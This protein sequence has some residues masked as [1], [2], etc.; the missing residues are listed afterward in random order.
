MKV[1]YITYLFLF[2]T[3]C[4]VWSQ[5]E[6]TSLEIVD[7]KHGYPLMGAHICL[8]SESGKKNYY[9]A[10]EDGTSA[11]YL[12]ENSECII[13]Y[14]GYKT[15]K[16]FLI[17]GTS[18]KLEMIP[19]LLMI[20]QV[21]VTASLQP[22]K[23]DQS[24]YKVGVVTAET[25]EKNGAQNIRDALRFQPN[26]NLLED[27]VLGSRI[28]MQGLE[29][30][31]VKFLIDGMPIIGR[32]GG[33]IDLSQIDM[34]QVDHI[35]IIEGPMSVVYGSN[36]LAGTIHIITKKNKYYKWSGSAIAYA[37]SIGQFNGSVSLQGNKGKSKF[38]FSSG[39][40]IF[41]GYDF[42]KSDRDMNWDPKDQINADA[43][44]GLDVKGWETKF[45]IR[46][47]REDLMIKGNYLNELSA[48]DTQFLTDRITYYGQFTKK[49]KA[50]NILTGQIS[51]H[52]Y[53]RTSQE[54][55]V[56]DGLNTK[57]KKGEESFNEFKT[58]NTR[59]SYGQELKSWLEWKIGYELTNELGSGE[60]LSDNDGVFENAIWS[61][62]RINLTDQL[63]FQPGI[64]LLHHNVYEAPLIY[65]AHLKWN[66]DNKWLGR[67]S[68]AKGFRT[69]S[70]KELYL[71]FV[72]A[73]HNI[74]GN[75]NLQPETSYNLTGTVNKT[76]DISE[77]SI[78]KMDVS[79]FYNHLFEV[80]ELTTGVDDVNY[81]YYN[82]ISE[83][84]THGGSF[85]VIY[86]YNNNLKL[87]GGVVV[88]GIGYDLNNNSDFNF[89]YSTDYIASTSYV[90]SKIDLSMQFDYKFSDS[91]IQLYGD[92]DE[93]IEGTV[94]SYEML[95]FSITKKL[96]NNRFSFTS[97]VKNILDVQNVNS[98]AIGG[99]HATE[100]NQLIAWGRTFFVSLKYNFNQI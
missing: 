69:P 39:Y 3:F 78:V 74:F 19:D 27:G 67:L 82:N 14:T 57:D 42:D 83:K 88:T 10:N 40:R 89:R 51:Y 16:L 94:S 54:Y 9:A 7:F 46:A 26:I 87:N 52:S 97:G 84:K 53:L 68:F 6:N 28:V 36:A 29:G 22:Q 45:G 5:N 50:E 30:Q 93:I 79:G 47:S 98:S 62:L 73:N 1:K 4:S 13:S 65:S 64:R 99:A 32:E 15:K 37:E 75:K 55:I 38:G 60:K 58:L 21:V 95:N 20:N 48:I 35:E 81:Y 59:L 77:A 72:D 91:R 76:L 2:T 49:N 23:V 41:K 61:N 90:W 44:Y 12:K 25:L 8:V 71:N 70:L 24:I 92:V 85:N 43:F 34:S 33:N 31:H 17:K 86:N 66:S 11:F 96:K 80:I 18:L 100:G 56:N 63:I